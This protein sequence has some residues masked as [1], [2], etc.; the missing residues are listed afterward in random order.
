MATVSIVN[1]FE[2]L[3]ISEDAATRNAESIAGK[4]FLNIDFAKAKIT[5]KVAV[6]KKIFQ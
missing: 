1:Q 3:I 6:L 2:N 4:V 5:S